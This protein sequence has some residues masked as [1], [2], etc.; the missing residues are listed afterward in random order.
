MLSGGTLFQR[1]VLSTALP[2]RATALR[3]GIRSIATNVNTVDT[4]EVELFSGLSSQWW[5][6]RGEFAMLHKM[7]PVRMEFIKQKLQEVQLE[8]GAF[9]ASSAAPLDGLDILDVGCGGGLLSEV[10]YLLSLCF[11]GRHWIFYQSLA[12]LGARTM[13]IDASEANVG[14][15]SA[16]AAG[17][18]QFARSSK[19]LTYLHTTA[20]GLLGEGKQYDV[21]CSM[22][23][24]EHVSTPSEFLHV[25]A[26]LVKASSFR[27][28][29]TSQTH[30]FITCP[31]PI[32]CS[33]EVICSSPPSHVH[34][35]PM[36]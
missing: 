6:E 25:C 18:P 28:F 13:G 12:R 35:W 34:R 30:A 4:S 15:A 26:Q 27:F 9:S 5:D 16:H 11:R 33:P 36:H 21:V 24:L 1:T 7:N 23:V 8:E 19:S 20:E 3:S 32:P 31:N 22:E 29:R 2:R 17:D 10:R 14:I